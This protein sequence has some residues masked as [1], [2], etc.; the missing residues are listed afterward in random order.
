M[1]QD[2]RYAFRVTALDVDGNESRLSDSVQVLVSCAFV[3]R[4]TLAVTGT[5]LSGLTVDRRGNIYALDYTNA[6]IVVFHPDGTVARRW[7]AL[8]DVM[9]LQYAY[10]RRVAVDDSGLVYLYHPR[11]RW[12]HVFDSTGA[13]LDTLDFNE[14][15]NYG[16]GLS[17][18]QDALYLAD[19][20]ERRVFVA[21]RSGNVVDTIGRE[22]SARDWFMS[23]D[24][25]AQGN[26][27]AL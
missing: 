18:Y 2:H 25:D 12:I 17:L 19:G 8:P 13:V 3:V 11:T 26:V 14:R 20:D 10:V 5:V 24:L 6:E 1:Q 27:H 9:S 21:D 16:V 23:M 4:E 7:P 15:G 22:W